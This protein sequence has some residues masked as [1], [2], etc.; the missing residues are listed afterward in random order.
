MP[1]ASA[2]SPPPVRV[3]PRKPGLRATSPHRYEQ[4]IAARDI[5]CSFVARRRITERELAESWGVT[6]RVARE[7]LLG[8]KPIHL[9]EILSLPHRIAL[10]LL[11][12]VRLVVL[13]RSSLSS[14]H[15]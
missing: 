2:S 13:A 14:S 3:E 15:G 12:E 4:A 8:D 1:C 6:P 11:D 9:G 7:K 5:L 10:E